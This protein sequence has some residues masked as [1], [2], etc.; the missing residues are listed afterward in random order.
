EVVQETLVAVANKIGEFRHS[1]RPGSFRAWL[2][3]QARWRIADQFR[4]RG[5]EKVA[6]QSGARGQTAEETSTKE[7][8][9]VLEVDPG[10]QHIWDSE[11]DEYAH[12]TAIGRVKSRVSARQFQ[13]FDLHVIQRLSVKEAA[14]AA[15]A[16]VASVYM[17]KSR[18]RRLL[19]REIRAL[20]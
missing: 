20:S 7:S 17:A 11:W 8:E 14:K 9:L 12:R 19:R 10:F 18:V 1:G 16:S 15:G 2:Y 3:Q 6:F 13:L 5:R 4:A